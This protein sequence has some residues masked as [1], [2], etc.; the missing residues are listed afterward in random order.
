M[1]PDNRP[2][3]APQVTFV[4][5]RVGDLVLPREVDQSSGRIV[6]F[7]LVL[8]GAEVG[9]Q[10][11]RPSIGRPSPGR[12]VSILAVPSM[13]NAWRALRLWLVVYRGPLACAPSSG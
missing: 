4:L 5:Y 12:L 8:A 2:A 11:S 6:V 7:Y 9:R 3:T 10:L 1:I 13:V